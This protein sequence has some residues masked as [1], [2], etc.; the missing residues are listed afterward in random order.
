M[1][2]KALLEMKGFVALRGKLNHRAHR[3]HRERLDCS[4]R[5]FS[6]PTHL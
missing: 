2:L 6:C 5:V 4:A 3:E 1:E